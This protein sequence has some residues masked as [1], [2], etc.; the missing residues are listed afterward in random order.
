MFWPDKAGD[1]AEKAVELTFAESF[2]LY[3]CIAFILFFGCDTQFIMAGL[4][5]FVK[6]L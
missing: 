1:T 6:D 4:E 5:E 2:V 3:S